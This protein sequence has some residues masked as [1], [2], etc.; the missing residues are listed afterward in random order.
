MHLRSKRETLGRALRHPSRWLVIVV[1]LVAVVSAPAATSAPF[2]ADFQVYVTAGVTSPQVI[3]TGGT[4][5][6]TGLAFQVGLTVDNDGGEE[7]SARARF[8]LPEGLRYGRDAPDA[9]EGCTLTDRVA[10]CLTGVTIGTDPSRRTAVW[11]WDA[12]AD[13]AGSYVLNAAIVQSSVADPSPANNATSATVVVRD[14]PAPG[15]G[16]TEGG[17]T[18]TVSAGAARVTPAKP[19]AGGLVAATVR[20]TAGGTAVRPGAVACSAT[21]G[22]TKLTGT[23]RAAR[24]SATCSFRTPRAAKGK[25]LRGT[26]SFSARG[27]RFSKRFAVTLG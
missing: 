17:G 3:Q 20:V 11:T 4:A 26:V 6:V 8:T 24:G 7:A 21:A 1:G 27:T 12:I 9:T 18:A 5:T 23:P 10:E 14:A 15:G 25:A 19:R 16:G 2:V 13:R 22:G